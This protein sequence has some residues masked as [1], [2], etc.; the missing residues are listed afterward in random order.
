MKNFKFNLEPL[1]R[2][3]EVEKKKIELELANCQLEI[4]A[5][6]NQ[7]NSEHKSIRDMLNEAE[8]SVNKN[9]TVMSL[10][11]IPSIME[12]KKYN[13]KLLEN[14]ITKLDEKRHE[15]LSRLNIKN[16]EIKNINE[17]KDDKLKIYKKQI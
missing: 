6:H 17:K 1:L 12:N 8:F 16:S 3:K 10:L 15:I 13:I 5:H 7:L 2:L 9:G 11:C 14:T 4:E